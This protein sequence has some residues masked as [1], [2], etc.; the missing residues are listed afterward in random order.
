MATAGELVNVVADAAGRTTKDVVL[1]LTR[2]T[3]LD[4]AGI[5]AIVRVADAH[6]GRVA[7]LPSA[8]VQRVLDL[9]GLGDATWVRAA[10]T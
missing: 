10:A 4:S 1:D 5:H 2:V 9:T 3:F 7:V 6:P 8:P